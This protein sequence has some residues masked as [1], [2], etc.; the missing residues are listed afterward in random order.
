MT[1]SHAGGTP[2]G[3]WPS[4]VKLAFKNFP[5]GPREAI[6]HLLRKSMFSFGQI[7][8]KFTNFSSRNETP[9]QH[10]AQ[11]KQEPIATDEQKFNGLFLVPQN[12]GKIVLYG[13]SLLWV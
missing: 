6:I 4:E 3:G 13:C 2:R 12:D 9:D 10:V 11:G 1:L 8:N 5:Y 7:K